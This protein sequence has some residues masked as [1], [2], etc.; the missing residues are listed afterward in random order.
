MIHVL[1]D[2]ESKETHEISRD[3]RYS[4]TG[5]ALFK[6]TLSLSFLA[7]FGVRGGQ[8]PSKRAFRAGA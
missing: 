5:R 4:Y 7:G 6:R 8:K 2:G 1:R 3:L